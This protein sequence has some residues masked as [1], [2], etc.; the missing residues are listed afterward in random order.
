MR[1]RFAAPMLICVLVASL[2]TA[3]GD[4]D[5]S[6]TTADT[7]GTSE[8]VSSTTTQTVAQGAP[9]IEEL[10]APAVALNIAHAGGDQSAPHSTMFAFKEAVA[11]GA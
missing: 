3:C 4:D 5:D 11:A 8:A 1:T 6:S 10:L 7:T 2:A 9:S